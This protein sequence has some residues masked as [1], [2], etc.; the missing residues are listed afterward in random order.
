MPS[1]AAATV[2]TA[3]QAAAWGVATNAV[4]AD[5]LAVAPAGK[6]AFAAFSARDL[7]FRRPVKMTAFSGEGVAPLLEPAVVAKKVVDG[8][9][10][11]L[12]GVEAADD[13]AVAKPGSSGAWAEEILQ[14]RLRQIRSR[15]ERE[16]GAAAPNALA[17][18]LEA[19]LTG[20][21]DA[22]RTAWP[23]G[24]SRSTYETERHVRW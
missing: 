21:A 13:A 2:A 3:E 6:R 7:F 12:V 23:Y 19:P 1:A 20:G 18:R 4:E 17:E 22:N 16:A 11:Y 8:K 10:V 14:N 9:T 5:A 24:H 15:V